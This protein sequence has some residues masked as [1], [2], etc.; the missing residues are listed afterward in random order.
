MTHVFEKCRNYDLHLRAAA[1]ELKERES[2]CTTEGNL[3]IWLAE[4]IALNPE[5]QFCKMERYAGAR[6]W[7]ERITKE[8]FGRTI[9]R[10]MFW[11]ARKFPDF[12]IAIPI[13]ESNDFI[14]R[15]YGTH[16]NPVWTIRISRPEFRLHDTRR[17]IR[18]G[19][20]WSTVNYQHEKRKKH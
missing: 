17:E 9:G 5:L 10:C 8:S 4:S 16:V 1:L 15:S 7:D 2:A 13:R 20:S 11:D 19:E 6:Q 12:Y 3:N 18:Y 14:I